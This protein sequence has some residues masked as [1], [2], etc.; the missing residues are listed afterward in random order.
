MQELCHLRYP[1]TG[2]GEE[3]AGDDMINYSKLQKQTVAEKSCGS[4]SLK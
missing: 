2:K 3:G 1:Q 4:V